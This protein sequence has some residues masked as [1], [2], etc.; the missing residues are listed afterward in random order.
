MSSTLQVSKLADLRAKTDR[1]L[2]DLID[3]LIAEGTSLAQEEALQLLPAVDDSLARMLLEG[4][5]RQL[6]EALDKTSR[7]VQ[8]ASSR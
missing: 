4:K 7:Q 6:H 3:R 5:L 1:E 2:V 8:T